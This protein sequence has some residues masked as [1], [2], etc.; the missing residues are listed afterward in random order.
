[1]T[2]NSKSDD[3]KQR[4]KS[5]LKSGQFY[6]IYE[7]KNSDLILEDKTKRGLE[8]RE[9]NN[10]ERYGVDA[11]KGMIYDIDGIGHRVGIRWHFPKPKYSLEYVIK[12]AE[13]MEAKYK[14]IREMTCPD[15]DY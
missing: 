7:N 14:S 15:D 4:E 9:L 12:I 8:V 2:Q 10:D 11:E 5:I 13:E 3:T 1:M 6:L